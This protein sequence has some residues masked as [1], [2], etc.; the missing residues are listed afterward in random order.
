MKKYEVF[1]FKNNEKIFIKA[2]NHNEAKE[3][4]CEQKGWSKNDCLILNKKGFN[5]LDEI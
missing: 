3:K 2:N 5:I 4:A 1:N